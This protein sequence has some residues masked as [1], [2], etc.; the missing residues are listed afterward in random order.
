MHKAAMSKLAGAT[1]SFHGLTR[2]R[3]IPEFMCLL[4]DV[5]FLKTVDQRFPSLPFGLLCGVTHS[6]AACFVKAQL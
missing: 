2:E 1:V 4:V 6:I 3:S 5:S